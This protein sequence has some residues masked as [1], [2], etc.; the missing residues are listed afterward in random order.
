MFKIGIKCGEPG[1]HGAKCVNKESGRICRIS[2]KPYFTKMVFLDLNGI[3]IFAT[4]SDFITPI[5][6]Q[7]NVVDLDILNYK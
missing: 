2:V 6:L 1:S 3:E 7:P 4:N 5:S